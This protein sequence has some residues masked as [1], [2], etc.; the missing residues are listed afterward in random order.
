[1]HPGDRVQLRA[2]GHAGLPPLP[3]PRLPLRASGRRRVV[4]V[5][6]GVLSMVQDRGRSGVASVGVPRAGAADPDGHRAANR[7]V[8]NDDD[9]AVI[10]VS[11]A[12]PSLRLECDAHAAVVGH[13]EVR[14]DGAPVAPDAVVPLAAGQV[15][16]VGTTGT[17]LRCSVALSGGVDVPTLFGSRSSDTLTGLGTGPLRAG[18]AL[19]L[20]LPRRPRGRLLRAG[21][22]LAG[23]RRLRVMAG[24]D[25]FPPEALDR[26]VQ[27]AWS[28]GASSNRMGVR[29]DG[30]PLLTPGP[31]PSRAMVTGAVQV[32]PDGHPVVLGCDHATVGG[33]PVIAAV[34]LADHG[35][36]GRCRPGDSLRFEVVDGAEAVRAREEAE[37]RLGRAV[38]GWYPDR[39]G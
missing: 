4:V 36:L 20:D 32:P 10:E 25:D 14:V 17:D 9:A 35:V 19:D 29:L 30:P 34:I 38:V 13:A 27:T 8:G 33:Y 11:A 23:A 24:P 15:L 16:A 2:V 5:S 31:V 21:P 1:V 18:D 39:A 12:G 7:L 26:L 28:V 6:P 37:R 22:G 3:G